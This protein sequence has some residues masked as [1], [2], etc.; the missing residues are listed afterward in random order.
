V[1]M[2]QIVDA[3]VEIEDWRT[4]EAYTTTILIDAVNSH[5]TDLVE[6]LLKNEADPNR[7][8]LLNVLRRHCVGLAHRRGELRPRGLGVRRWGQQDRW[9]RG[10]A[11][12]P[13]G[14]PTLQPWFGAQAGHV[15]FDGRCILGQLPR[16]CRVGVPPAPPSIRQPLGTPR[17]LR[18]QRCDT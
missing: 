10:G 15:S 18:T 9:P 6:L 5:N 11:R 3:D 4:K 12:K 17:P 8:D 1:A 13:V 7:A 14:G 2:C 16:G